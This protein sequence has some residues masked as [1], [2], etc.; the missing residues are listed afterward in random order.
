MKKLFLFISFILLFITNS[1]AQRHFIY[2]HEVGANIGIS[3]SQTDFLAKGPFDGKATINGF[4]IEGNHYLHI[5]PRRYGSND[6]LKHLVLKTSLSINVSNFDNS[7][8]GTENALL[9]NPPNYTYQTTPNEVLLGRLSSKTTLISIDNNIQYYFK[10]V[11]RFLHKYNKYRSK[12]KTNPFISIGLG[13]NYLNATTNY[14]NEALINNAGGDG[15]P[16]NYGNNSIKDQSTVVISGNFG[17]GARYKAS[18][19]YDLVGQIGFKYF[20][21]DWIDGVNP[22]IESNVI[23]DFNTVISVGLIY[24]L[25]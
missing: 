3:N 15:Y 23:N 21:S 13:I 1:Y 16:D 2:Q 12:S 10:D 18:K 6:I 11:I 24:H 5:L 17:F 8:F 20:L 4:A 22:D 7:S 25:F 9:N 14:D 19:K